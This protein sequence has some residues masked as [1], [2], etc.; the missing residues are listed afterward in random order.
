MTNFR[1]SERNVNLPFQII[2]NLTF[3]K[4]SAS[5]SVKLESKPVRGE[6]YDVEAV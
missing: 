2:Q 4:N 6:S 3:E 5:L 1:N